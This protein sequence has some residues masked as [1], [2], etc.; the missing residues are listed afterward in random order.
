MV[1]LL[2][3]GDHHHHHADHDD[4]GPHQGLLP[5]SLL[6]AKPYLTSANFRCDTINVNGHT[7]LR[8]S[9]NMMTPIPPDPWVSSQAMPHINYALRQVGGAH[10]K[11][12]A[13]S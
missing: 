13:D 4:H 3:D 9:L 2:A 7:N 10:L 6:T 8:L 5:P 1:S 12:L 11:L